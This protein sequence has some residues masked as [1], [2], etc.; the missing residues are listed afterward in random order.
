MIQLLDFYANWCGPCKIMEPIFDEL[1]KDYSG[2]VEFKRVDVE[3]DQEMSAKFDVRSIP[4]FVLIENDKEL[5]RKIGAMPK[6]IVKR[7]LD[8][9]VK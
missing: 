5:D 3:V 7:W 8:G 1:A 6:E 4:T 2:K 9:H